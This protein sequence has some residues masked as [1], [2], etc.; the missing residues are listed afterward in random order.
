[1]AKRAEYAKVI[2]G[3]LIMVIIVLVVLNFIFLSMATQISPAD[4]FYKYAERLEAED[5][6]GAID[7]TIHK[8]ND[9]ADA[10]AFMDGRAKLTIHEVNVVLKTEMDE[11]EL[12]RIGLTEDYAE[13]NFN[14]DVTDGCIIYFTATYYHNNTTETDAGSLPCLKIDSSWYLSGISAVKI[15]G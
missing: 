6:Q 10:D 13:E 8:F 5:G 1:M 15:Q 2:L 14:V 12:A 7:F 9:S 4:V 3:A 11:N